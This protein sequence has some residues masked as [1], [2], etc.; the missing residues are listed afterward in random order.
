LVVSIKA[1]LRNMY[2]DIPD[3]ALLPIDTTT[4]HIVPKSQHADP[5]PEPPEITIGVT[6][7][8]I[9][10]GNGK[11][12]ALFIMPNGDIAIPFIGVSIE[13]AYSLIPQNA[14]PPIPIPTISSQCTTK[15]VCSTARHTFNFGEAAVGMKVIMFARYVYIKHPTKSGGYGAGVPGIVS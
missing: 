1:A 11:M 2:G 8:L 15:D 10:L 12:E 4:L 6:I 7:K 9:P 5:T 13:Y 14:V 3:N